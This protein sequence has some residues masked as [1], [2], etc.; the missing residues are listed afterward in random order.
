M[1]PK[2]ANPVRRTRD[3]TAAALDPVSVSAHVCVYGTKAAIS[4]VVAAATQCLEVPRLRPSSPEQVVLLLCDQA[5]EDAPR[6]E[7]AHVDVE[8]HQMA[9]GLL[10]EIAL[11]GL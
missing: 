10:G 1:A 3:A 11:L 4:P 2:A 8:S 6:L 7:P 9:G 5:L